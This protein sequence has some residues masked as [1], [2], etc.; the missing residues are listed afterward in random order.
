MT[1][2][3]AVGHRLFA[4]YAYAPNALG[5][6][7]P[8]GAADLCSVACGDGEHVDV[9]TIAAQ[10]SGA[11]P[12][13]KVLAD[14]AGS[15][16]PLDETVVRGYWTGN[17]LT[18]RVD[19]EAY[20]A[21]LLQWIQHEAGHYWTHLSDD[22]LVEAA[23]THAFHVFAVYP[24]SRLLDT[25]RPEPLHVLDSC[26]IGWAQVVAVEDREL[27]VR[28]MP[29]EYGD[30]VLSLG[31]TREER[32]A[33]RVDGATFIGAVAEGDWV[34]VHW[35]FACDRLTEAQVASLEKWTRWQLEVM[36]PR[37]AGQVG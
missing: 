11:W 15:A 37:L 13:Q 18:D 12:Y 9:P 17:D 24:W 16:D 35:G 2:Q 32:V 10:F 26:R 21:A 33:Y 20:G 23:P 22:L 31:A 14:L 36:G 34:A 6:C 30:R 29:L 1:S 27:L 5:Y 28:S 19:R 25:G 8:Q 3:V 7:G 4:Q